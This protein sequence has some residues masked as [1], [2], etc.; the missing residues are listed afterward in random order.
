MNTQFALPTFVEPTHMTEA[1]Q[2]NLLA[3]EATA[4]A[5]AAWLANHPTATAAN[6][7]DFI[8]TVQPVF[9]NA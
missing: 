2:R 1:H 4:V 5:V 9:K 3:I 8:N 7:K 6:V